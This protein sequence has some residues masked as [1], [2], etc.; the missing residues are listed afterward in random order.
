MPAHQRISLKTD[1]EVSA[2]V[3]SLLASFG[4]PDDGPRA[5]EGFGGKAGHTFDDGERSDT[6]AGSAD[7][8]TLWGKRKPKSR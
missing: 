5:D 3:D 6:P 4:V 7:V 8:D 2:A 1:A